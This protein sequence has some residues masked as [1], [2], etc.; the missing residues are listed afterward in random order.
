MSRLVDAHPEGVGGHDHRRG[1]AHEGGLGAGPRLALHARVVGDGVDAELAPHVGR[2]LLRRG[3]RA[4]VDDRGQ[5]VGGAQ[6]GHQAPALV[7]AA[8]RGHDGEAEVGAVE[9]GADADGV[10]Q[11]QPANHVGGDLRGRRRRRG[12][13]R[14]R[15]HDLRGLREAEVVGPEVVAPLRHAVRLVDHEEPDARCRQALHEPGG[16]EAFGRDVEQP[17]VSARSARERLAVRLEILLG[18][19]Q[20]DARGAAA[21]AERLDLVLH[22]RDEWRHDDGEVVAHERRELVAE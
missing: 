15:S 17:Q 13:D 3:P 8:A 6:R 9:A 21:G 14:A 7:E 12:D 1:A 16:G 4:G 5:G 2:Q 11:R 10:A 22:E 19:D 18:V 20:R